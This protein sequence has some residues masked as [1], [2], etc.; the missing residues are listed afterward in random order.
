MDTDS[1]AHPPLN[2][3][4]GTSIYDCDG[5][6]LGV[7]GANG[8]QEQYLIMAEGH[9]FHHDVAVPI[10]AVERTDETGIHLNRSRREIQ[11]LTMG[12]WSS[13]GNRDLDTGE[14]ASR[15]RDP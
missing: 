6:R 15:M 14:P 1:S 11:D 5:N 12:G 9:V 2:F 8:V 3:T 13:L 7:V 10:S 4:P